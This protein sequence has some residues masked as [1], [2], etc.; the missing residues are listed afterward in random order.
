VPVR[1]DG[2]VAGTPLYARYRALP[3]QRVVLGQHDPDDTGPYDRARDA[4]PDFDRARQR[5]ADLQE[6]LWAE[7]QRSLL[8]VLQAMDTGGKDGTIRDV[9]AFVDPQGCQVWS[10][11]VPTPEELDH[12]F[13]W[14]YHA[15]VPARGTIGI[16]NRSHY[17]DVLVARV[18]ELVPPRVWQP[19][20]QLINRFEELLAHTDT[21]ILKFFLHISK[22][23]QKERLEAR[24]DDPEKAWKFSTGDVDE[25]RHWDAY[26]AAYEEALSRCSTDESPWFLVPANKKWYRNVVV[27]SVVADTLERMAPRVPAPAPGVD[28]VKIPD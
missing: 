8:V 7:H 20:Y 4:A 27:A 17:E 2:G 6:L 19:R 21:T 10:F 11:K 9:F 13:L 5:I 1:Y 12:D 15:R 14:R 23:E 24:R 18:R 3:G 25:R 22:D 28:K 16:F 26:M